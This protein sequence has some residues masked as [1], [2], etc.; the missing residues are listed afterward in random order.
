MTSNR[1]RGAGEKNRKATTPLNNR[2]GLKT[3]DIL[4][5]LHGGPKDG[6]LVTYATPYPKVI[7]MP[8]KTPSGGV[9]FLDYRQRGS[10]KDQRNHYDWIEND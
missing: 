10:A 9:E 7:V 4:L 2:K 6:E 3:G 8:G 5:A 1:E